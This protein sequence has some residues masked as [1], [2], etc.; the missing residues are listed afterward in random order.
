MMTHGPGEERASRSSSG[1][2]SPR[3][4]GTPMNPT[5]GYCTNVH[6]GTSLESICANLRAHALSVRERLAVD[7]L[8]VGLW[9]PATV[10]Q[11]LED[12]K[13]LAK[14]ASCLHDLRLHPYTLN[15]FPFGD[16]HGAVV[17]RDVYR[18][19]WWESSRAEYTI[20]LAHQLAA[21]LPEGQSASIS[22]L[23]LGWPWPRGP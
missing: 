3:R 15:G 10:S 12:P 11:Q 5:I 17:K 9:I 1:N 23:P 18:P 2:D 21:L 20:R 13:Q 4:A 22:T 7:V 19:A 8:P 6:A 16:F 14:L